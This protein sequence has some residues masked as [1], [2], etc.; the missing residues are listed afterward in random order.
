MSES[1][2]EYEAKRLQALREHHVLDTPP[3]AGFDRLVGTAKEI[4]QTPI[5]LISL[6]DDKRQWFKARMGLDVSETPRDIS[7]CNQAIQ[8]SDIFIIPDAQSDARFANNPFVVSD[9]KIRF[10]AGVPL[11]TPEGYA[12]G[13][14]CVID[15]EPRQLTPAQIQSLKALGRQTS[16]E[17]QRRRAISRLVF[18][19]Q[20]GQQKQSQFFKKLTARFGLAVLSVL[21]IE[22]ISY[23]SDGRAAQRDQWVAHTLDVI[24]TIESVDANLS[25]LQLATQEYVITAPTETLRPREIAVNEINPRLQKLRSLTADNAQQQQNLRQLEPAIQAELAALEKMVS[26]RQSQNLSAVAQLLNLEERSTTRL[27][28]RTLLNEMR[29]EEEQLLDKRI[30]RAAVSHKVASISSILGTGTVLIVLFTT[31]KLIRQEIQRRVQAEEE[32]EQQRELLEVTLSSIG[33]AVITTDSSRR[34][35]FLNPVAEVLTGWPDQEVKGLPIGDILKLVDISTGAPVQSPFETTLEKNIVQGLANNIGLYNREGEIVPIDDSCAPIISKD[36]TLR[37]AVMVFRDVTERQ[38]AEEETQRALAKEK[39]LNELKTSFISMISHDIRTPLAIILSS[40]DL[41]Q[42]Y[43]AKATEEKK[44]RYFQQIRTAVQ[45][46]Q[47]LLDD[48]LLVSRAESGA[49]KY[50]PA[51]LDLNEFCR[52][53]VEEIQVIAGEHYDI[54]FTNLGTCHHVCMDKKLMQHI[55]T[56]LL[57]NAVKYSPKGSWIDFEVE[58]S[59]G[60]GV[61]RIRDQGIGIPAD[62]LPRLFAAFHRGKNV[63]AISGTG[64]GLSIVKTCVDMHLGRISVTSELEKGTTFEVTLPLTETSD[65]VC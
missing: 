46:M 23:W 56:N 38:Q 6:V 54:V 63:G 55:F 31:Y 28:I 33:D 34:I 21:A 11:R 59:Q 61:F 20:N 37:G 16:V 22:A 35:T 24:S 26:V 50:E 12:L 60:K 52:Q 3:E 49:I 13:T 14:L 15:H 4:C 65:G 43:A 47:D 18:R 51:P 53:L 40:I 2:L 9:P 32:Q 29:Q 39:E 19:G 5:A 25:D 58:C 36:G 7:F 64:L 44:Q 10:Y 41:L 62:D 42:A 45:R 1:N 30:A 17:L 27:A 8:Q 48:V 57:S